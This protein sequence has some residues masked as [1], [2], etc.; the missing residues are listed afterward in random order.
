MLVDAVGPGF[1]LIPW[2]PRVGAIAHG[3]VILILNVKAL[4]C[5]S[6]F[7]LL[8]TTRNWHCFIL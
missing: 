5:V 6:L 2:T 1:S 4:G 8:I 3:A 7:P